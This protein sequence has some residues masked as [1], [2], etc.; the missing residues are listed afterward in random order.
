[1]IFFSN[2]SFIEIRLFQSHV[3]INLVHKLFLLPTERKS[4]QIC[5]LEKNAGVSKKFRDVFFN[6]TNPRNRFVHRKQIQTST[7]CSHAQFTRSKYKPPQIALAHSSQEVNTNL[8]KLL[9]RTAHKKQTQT[10][11][12][13]SR[14]QFTRSKCKLSQ[15]S[16]AQSSQEA[17]IKI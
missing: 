9:S 1:M 4:K 15:T 5:L 14:V 12:N 3:Q 6:R 7:N 11:T 13:C 17:N 2:R 10:S 16:L 8:H